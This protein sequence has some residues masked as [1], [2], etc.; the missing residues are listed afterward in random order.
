MGDIHLFLW[1]LIKYKN[2]KYYYLIFIKKTSISDNL[3]NNICFLSLGT[4]IATYWNA[5]YTKP[6][7]E[8]LPDGVR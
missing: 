6:L 5:C 4:A 8:Q 7:I 2:V 3:Q 1:I